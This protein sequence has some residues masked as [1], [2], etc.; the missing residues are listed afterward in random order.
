MLGYRGL[1]PSCPP[2]FLTPN[3]HPTTSVCDTIARLAAPGNS[4]FTP[5][6]F[7]QFVCL[8]FMDDGD[9]VI[10][11]EAPLHSGLTHAA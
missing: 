5:S 11:K 7:W 10:Q 3:S 8:G 4:V 2:G 1:H 6:D 9:F